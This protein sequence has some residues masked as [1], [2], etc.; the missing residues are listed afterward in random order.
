VTDGAPER[1]TAGGPVTLSTLIERVPEGWTRVIYDG[2]PYGLSRTTRVG[3]RVITITAEEL[4]GA[5]FVSA[6]VYRATAAD[7]LRA[8]EMPDAKVLDFLRG[9]APK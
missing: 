9:W 8:C 1:T 6:N 2:R 4:G 3:G 7:H 5:D